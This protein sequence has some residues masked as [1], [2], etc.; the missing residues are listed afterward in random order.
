[1]E[2]SP[3]PPRLGVPDLGI[4]VGLRIPHYEAV[5]AEGGGAG[6]DWFE[7]ISDNFMVEGGLPLW[8]LA[9]VLERFRLVQHGVSLSIGSTDELDWDYLRKLKTL[10]QRTRSPWVSDHLCWG[11]A[12]GVN[13][14]DLLPLPYTGAV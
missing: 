9:R 10:L 8:N 6:I 4:G 1:M 11:G 5:F 7:I 3:L 14:H 13:L 12:Q 2:A